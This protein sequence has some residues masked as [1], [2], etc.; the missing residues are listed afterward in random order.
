MNPISKNELSSFLSSSFPKQLEYEQTYLD[1]VNIQTKENAISK[2]Y[3]HYLDFN[4]NP[5]I[6]DWFIS[7]LLNLI[8]LKSNK[9][10]NLENYSVFLEY[11]TI[12]NLGR[13]DIVIDSKET[14]SAILIENKIYHWLHNDLEN[15][16]ETFSQYSK[17]NRVGIVLA[18]TNLPSSNSNFIS[19]SHIEWITSVEK[20]IDFSILSEREKIHLEDFIINLKY[21]TNET[22][23]NENIKFYLDHSSKIEQILIFKDEASRF[24]NAAINSVASKNNWEVYGSTNNYKQ[25]WDKKNDIRVFYTLFPDEILQKKE[26]KL[27]IEIDGRAR[28]YYDSLI[29]EILNLDVFDN[30][31]IK[32]DFKNKN[33]A[34]LGFTIYP[35]S[36]NNFENLSS[37]I[38]EKIQEMETKRN[39]I[40]K[41]LISIGY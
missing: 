15:Y 40:Y 11:I 8:E 24:I 32:S 37:F 12:D 28:Q 21:I 22:V 18:L 34:H 31:F 41:E 9:K 36:E 33:S 29:K 1:I 23:M 14:Q 2:I 13:I 3:A 10:L 5:K 4:K 30:T 17:N 19:I 7:S 20:I 27:V 25:I 16:W 26:L 39:F 38:D 6:S 35:L